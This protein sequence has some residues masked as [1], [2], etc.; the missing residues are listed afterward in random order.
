METN[1]MEDEQ[2]LLASML[3]NNSIVE[4]VYNT[5]KPST[6]ITPVNRRIYETILSLN[7]RGIIADIT[8]V[9]KE[10]GNEVDPMY[11]SGLTDL[12]STSGNWKYYA[13]NVKNDFLK[14]SLMTIANETTSELMQHADNTR[15]DTQKLVDKVLRQITDVTGSVTGSRCYDMTELIKSEFDYISKCIANKKSW[16][17]L[18]TGYVGLNNIINGLQPVYMVIGARPSMGK[19]AFAHKMAMHISKTDRVL[20]IELE[21]SPRQLTERA[22]SNQTQIPFR[23]IQTG[24]MTEAAMGKLMQKMEEIAANKNFIPCEIP[25]RQLSDIVNTCR[26]EVRNRKAK[27]IFIDHFGLIRC[28]YNGAAYDKARYISNTLQQLQR[29]LGVPVVVLSQLGRDSEGNKASLASF[30]G[31]GAIEEDA[32]ICVFIN[33]ER[34]ESE[35]DT[36]IETEIVV[37]KNRDGAVGSVNMTFRPEIVDFVDNTESY[38]ERKQREELEKVQREA[39]A[40]EPAPV[41]SSLSFIPQQK[42]LFDESEPEQTEPVY[43]IF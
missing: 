6:F 41:E 7:K 12:V 21:M 16:L 34:A 18:D 30:R 17:G 32:D 23:R 25:G 43:D 27:A 20:F 19:T 13:D 8:T 15:F 5:V 42:D 26:A 37:G 3:I 2:L 38:E 35:T 14:R 22:I 1:K 36:N 31:S 29:E 28:N 24:M 11:I 4:N 9:Y 33:R 10:I 40:K 39:E